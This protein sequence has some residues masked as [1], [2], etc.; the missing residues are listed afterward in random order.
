MSKTKHMKAR[1]SQRGINEEMVNFVMQYA[2]EVEGDKWIVTRKASAAIVE[3]AERLKRLALRAAQSG[4][5]VVV[6]RG[7]TQITTYRLVD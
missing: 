5:L 4:G 3:L 6:V 1:M 2:E 7:D